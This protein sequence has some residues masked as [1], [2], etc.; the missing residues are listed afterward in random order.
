M[1][2]SFSPRGNYACI[3]ERRSKELYV[4]RVL[5]VPTFEPILSFPY[6]SYYKEHWPLLQFNEKDTLCFRISTDQPSLEVYDLQ[7]AQLINQQMLNHTV[8]QM[9]ISPDPNNQFIICMLQEH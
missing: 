3:M 2:A 1:I 5:S 6:K 4:L 9:Y 8:D 7:Q